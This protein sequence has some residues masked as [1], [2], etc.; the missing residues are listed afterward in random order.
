MDEIK[1]RILDE[2]ADWMAA[3]DAIT[4]AKIAAR[5]NQVQGGN[6]GDH[7]SIG[8]GVS[9]MRINYAKG[10]RLYY[11]IRGRII[12]ILLCGGIKDSQ[13]RDIKH[14]KKLNKEV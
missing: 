6:F 11:T 12:V 13:K 14:A 4:K 7:K 3:Q 8:D 2:F 5:L 1:L 9:E 10:Y